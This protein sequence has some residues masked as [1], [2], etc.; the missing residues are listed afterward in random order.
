MERRDT[1]S[2]LHAEGGGDED[3]ESKD[4]DTI[5]EE[6]PCR[7]HLT[8]RCQCSMDEV[9]PVHWNSLR[10]PHAR[11]PKGKQLQDN[12]A[13]GG[14]LRLRVLVGGYTTRTSTPRHGTAHASMVPGT[15]APRP[16]HERGHLQNYG[17]CTDR[18]EDTRGKTKMARARQQNRRRIC[19]KNDATT[20]L[21]PGRRP[22]GRPK[23][24]WLDGLKEDM[25]CP[26]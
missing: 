12:G 25:R 24:R 16:R 6:Y 7:S 18:R 21:P 23:K 15:N 13:P 17:R 1:A 11:P 9:A 20:Q 14:S 2:G 22:R 4:L 3:L 5:F 10:S 26:V 8:A 19:G